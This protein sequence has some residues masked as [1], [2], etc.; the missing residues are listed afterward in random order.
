VNIWVEQLA[1][2]YGKTITASKSGGLGFATGNARITDIA[3]QITT[4]LGANQIGASDVLVIDPGV[5]E[6]VALDAANMT[7]AAL[8]DAAKAAGKALAAQ[9]VR[10]TAAG[11]KH[12]VIA[13][14][15]DFGKTPFAGTRSTRLTQA[16]RDFNDSL[17]VELASVT[18]S[19]LLVDNEAYFNTIYNNATSLLGSGA[20]ITSGACT[21]TITITTPCTSTTVV[22]SPAYNLHVFADTLYP[23]P[24]A[25]RLIGTN[26]YNQVRLR[27]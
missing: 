1:A 2:S 3:A 15:P 19:V 26:A 7:D 22:A 11:G 20:V 17:K 18:N 25:H 12:V 27:W 21:A 23:S 10:L 5:A 13:N 8:N 4:F 9:V 16:T 6:L 14:A 24:A